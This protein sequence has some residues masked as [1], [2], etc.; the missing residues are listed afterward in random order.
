MYENVPENRAKFVYDAEICY[1]CRT[2]PIMTRPINL[3]LILIFLTFS[4]INAG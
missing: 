4:L 3:D 2:D 1:F